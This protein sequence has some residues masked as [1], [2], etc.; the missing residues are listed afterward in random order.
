MTDKSANVRFAE[1]LHK[2]QL[3]FAPDQVNVAAEAQPADRLED[4]APRAPGVMDG[5]CRG[6]TKMTK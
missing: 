6:M 5:K 3:Q 1:S 4:N 2:K